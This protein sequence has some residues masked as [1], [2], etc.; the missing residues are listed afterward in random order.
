[1]GGKP[2]KSAC[3]IRGVRIIGVETPLPQRP[4]NC[5]IYYKSSGR[6]GQV[7]VYGRYGIQRMPTT[8][9][10]RY[11]HRLGNLWLQGTLGRASPRGSRDRGCPPYGVVLGFYL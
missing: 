1:M 6:S 7:T 2:S 10:P 5:E 8:F 9:N 4:N 3:E 11:D